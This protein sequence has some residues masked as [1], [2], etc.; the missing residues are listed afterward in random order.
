MKNIFAL[1]L[2]IPVSLIL[3]SC[4]DNPATSSASLESFE[5]QLIDSI[6]KI[7]VNDISIVDENNIY[8]S[9]SKIGYKINNGVKIGFSFCLNP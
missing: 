5:W 3:Y 2:V 7:Y 9:D 4:S 8:L 1:L 6:E